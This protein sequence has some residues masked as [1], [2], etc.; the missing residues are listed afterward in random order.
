MPGMDG[1]GPNGKGPRTGWGAGRCRPPKKDQNN[2]ARDVASETQDDDTP[3]GWG[4]GLGRLWR[5]RGGGRGRGRGWGQGR[6]RGQ[7]AAGD[8]STG[9]T[10]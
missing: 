3:T 2:D 7:G 1:T 6:G 9:S 5:N 8:D 4:G 10:D